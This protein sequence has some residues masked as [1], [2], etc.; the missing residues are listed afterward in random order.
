MPCSRRRSR[1]RRA[2]VSRRATRR[3]R[4]LDIRLAHE[5]LERREVFALQ[6]YQVTM[7]SGMQFGDAS[8]GAAF[9]VQPLTASAAPVM[10]ADAAGA[11]LAAVTG[12]V[13]VVLPETAGVYGFPG[14]RF[15]V[16]S[17]ATDVVVDAGSGLVISFEDWT[18]GDNNNWY[19]IVSA[20]PVEP[21]APT[22]PGPDAGGDD[23]CPIVCN[24]GVDPATG[25]PLTRAGLGVGPSLTRMPASAGLPSP[26][27]NGWTAGDRP[28]LTQVP[29][30]PGLPDTLAVVSSAADRRVW[31]SSGTSGDYVR[32]ANLATADRLTAS[33]GQYLYRTA[34]GTVFTFNGF[35]AGTPAAAR[36]QVV[37]RTDSS[38]N[39]TVYSFNPDGSTAGMRS[40]T[41]EPSGQSTLVEVQDY[42]YVPATGKVSRIDVRRGDG[43]LVRS[44]DYA[45]HD[46]TSAFGTLGDLASITVRD[47]AGAILDAQ[48]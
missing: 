2:A 45:Y 34:S 44:V 31:E 20:T 18:D 38:G 14:P 4:P 22:G 17:T 39:R 10:A 8:P 28:V 32:A 5:S 27:G 9:E 33:D 35:D 25:A 13:Q 30:P 42:V 41:A 37:S 26:F 15:T 23:D 29:R 47:P 36:G 11:V 46:G 1:Y 6:A 24:T 19:W 43:T 12:R 48:A 40:F 3:R 7:Q 16:G 21:Q